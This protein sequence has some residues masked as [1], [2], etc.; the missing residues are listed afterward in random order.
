MANIYTFSEVKN[1]VV[2]T[3]ETKLEPFFFNLENVAELYN[4]NS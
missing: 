3:I 1:L 4:Y 2:E